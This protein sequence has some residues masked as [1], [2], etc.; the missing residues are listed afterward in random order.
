MV[1]CEPGRELSYVST[2]GEW[3]PAGYGSYGVPRRSGFTGRR[4]AVAPA[5]AFG[6]GASVLGRQYLHCGSP[7]A[8]VASRR[9]GQATH[10]HLSSGTGDP[11]RR[12]HGHPR[13]LH[14][15][16]PCPRRLSSTGPRLALRVGV[17]TQ[18]DEPPL[19]SRI[20][21]FA[22][23]RGPERLF[24]HLS[25]NAL[26]PGGLSVFSAQGLVAPRAGP[27]CTPVAP[28]L[29]GLSHAFLTAG[30]FFSLFYSAGARHSASSIA[31]QPERLQA[32]QSS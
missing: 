30:F 21:P 20:P 19:S 25:R 8:T 22:P 11:P 23:W 16:L 27:A 14:R 32:K 4:A 15:S 9:Y 2:D 7:K 18:S 26:R 12:M 3:P 5:S 24:R 28:V 31:G 13:R 10:G 1:P 17:R 6:S 29:K